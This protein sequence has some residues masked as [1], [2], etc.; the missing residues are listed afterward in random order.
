MYGRRCPISCKA[1]KKRMPRMFIYLANVPKRSCSQRKKGATGRLY[2]Q[3]GDPDKSMR[4]QYSQKEKE[5][6]DSHREKRKWLKRL[7]D[8]NITAYNTAD[9]ELTVNPKMFIC[10]W[11]PN[12]YEIGEPYLGQQNDAIF[13]TLYDYDKL[14]EED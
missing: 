11:S 8:A 2:D 14:H 7:S 4:K 13:I 3:L 5:V 6:R 1:A 10:A 12:E 9:E